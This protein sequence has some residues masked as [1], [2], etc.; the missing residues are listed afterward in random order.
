MIERWWQLPQFLDGNWVDSTLL[1]ALPEGPRNRL[2]PANFAYP[3]QEQHRLW[4]V[5]I[6][7]SAASPVLELEVKY[8]AGVRQRSDRRGYMFRLALEWTTNEADRANTA[9]NNELMEK[10][11]IVLANKNTKLLNLDVPD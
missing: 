6:D 4:Q 5:W 10:D 11:G 8:P 9:F 1:G 7:S 2:C 3:S